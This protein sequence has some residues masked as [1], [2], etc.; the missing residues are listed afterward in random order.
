MKKLLIA[1]LSII[2]FAPAKADE[3]MWIPM[4]I[5]QNFQQMQK[6]GWKGTAEDIYSVNKS[7]MKD[8]IV[9]FGGGCTAEMISADGLLM[10]NHHCGYGNISSLSTVENNYLMNGFVANTKDAELP[11]PGL[12]VKFLVRMEDV[13]KRVRKKISDAYGAD[14]SKRLREVTKELQKE[15][16]NNGAYR[17]DVRSFYSGNKY[18]MLIYEVYTD[19]RLV[20][21]PPESLGKFGGDTDNWM[22]PRHTCDFSMF[23]VYS[24]NNNRPAK[25]SKNNRP[26]HPKHHLPVSLKGV[27]DGDFAMIMGYPGRTTRYLTSQGIDLSVNDFNPTIVKI[28]DKRLAV[29]REVMDRKPAVDLQYASTY[30]SV[31]NYWKYFIGQ[32]EQLKRLKI[33]DQKMDE[34][35]EFQRWSKKEARY[36]KNLFPDYAEAYADYKPY[37]KHYLYFYEAFGSPKLTQLALRVSG[38]KKLIDS[39]ADIDKINKALTALKKT[40]A[41]LI[42]SMDKELDQNLFAA[43]NQMFYED[44]PRA[45]HPSIFSSEVFNRFGTGGTEKTFKDY[46][47]YLYQKTALLNDEAFDRMATPENIDKLLEDPAIVYAM[48]VND[49]WKKNY[50]DIITDYRYER[51]ELDRAYLGGMLEKNQGKLMYPDANSTMRLSYGN[52][53]AYKPKDGVSFSHYTTAAGLMEK[54]KPGD[55]EFDLQTKIVDLVRRKDYGDY[56]NSKGELVTCFITNNDITGGNSGSPVINGNGEWIGAAFDGNWEAMS[57]DIAFDKRFKRTIIVDARYIMW[58]LDKV[59]GGRPLLDEMTIRN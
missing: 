1:F 11:C 15:N 49:N 32:T 35:A 28:R 50:A 17:V 38:L 44:V 20:A 33:Q 30:A 37:V 40:R 18:Y 5:G 19:V 27:E 51:F 56:A 47:S 45:Q 22:W 48:N 2:L 4:L 7:S 24:N 23:R 34:E 42:E 3:G 46:T 43:M 21:A 55:K 29:M 10:T 52:V 13:T 16:D 53:K 14:V 31:A 58:V 39:K 12:S 25:Y 26:Y 59:L 57:G 36:L 54:Y 8:A 41:S 9:H 6:L